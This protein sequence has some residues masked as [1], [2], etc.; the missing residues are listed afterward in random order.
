MMMFKS[1]TVASL[2][3]AAY[4]SAQDS[5]Y[6]PN[7]TFDVSQSFS[8]NNNNPTFSALTNVFTDIPNFTDNVNLFIDMLDLD[9]FEDDSCDQA[10]LEKLVGADS[11][12][13]ALKVQIETYC[14]RN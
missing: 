7:L 3:M 8:A 14:V 5:N 12:L 9:I 13:E 6:D 10:C 2:S 4:I 1:I 11:D